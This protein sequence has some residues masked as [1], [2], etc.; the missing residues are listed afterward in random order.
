MK[1]PKGFKATVDIKAITDWI[2][3][4]LNGKSNLNKLLREKKDEILKDITDLT[5]EKVCEKLE[6]RGVKRRDFKDEF[7]YLVAKTAGYKKVKRKTIVKD[8]GYVRSVGGFRG[9]RGR[10][11]YLLLMAIPASNYFSVNVE[12]QVR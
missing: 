9:R 12:L 2:N 11:V 3:T 7:S 5:K 4:N 8:Y 10:S 1:I 6:F